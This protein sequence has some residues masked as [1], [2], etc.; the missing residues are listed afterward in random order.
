MILRTGVI[1]TLLSSCH[2]FQIGPLLSSCVDACLRGCEEIRQVQKDQL[3]LELKDSED[4]RSVVTEADR[5]AQQILVGSLRAEWGDSLKI[6]AEE[7]MEIQSKEYEPLDKTLFEDDLGETADIDPNDI[8]VFIDPLD[9]THEYVEGR[10][11]NCQVLV[12]I[13][14][15]GEAVAGAIGMPFP[16]GEGITEPTVVYGLAD[17]GSGVKG[18]QMTRGPFPLDKFID[19]LKYPRPHIAI[20][21]SPVAVVKEAAEFV[22][23]RSEGSLVAYSGAGNKI[24]AASIGEVGCSIQHKVGGPWDLC[25]PVAVAKA[26]GADITDMFGDEIAICKD[27]APPRCNERGFVVT[28]PGGQHDMVIN[29]I[30]R[31]PTVLAYQKSLEK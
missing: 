19:G 1:F 22:A 10:F 18:A 6:V 4:P 20:T 30:M 24:L 5:R 25:A 29:T 21:E 3:E 28:A 13:A 9:G 12:G 26:M 15:Q 11:E 2:S 31:S 17:M 23:K 16:M 27:D 8:T 14:I 7:D